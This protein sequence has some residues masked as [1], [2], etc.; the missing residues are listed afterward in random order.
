ME[1]LFSLFLVSILVI[2]IYYFKPY[3]NQHIQNLKD[4]VPTKESSKVQEILE[5]IFRNNTPEEIDSLLNRVNEELR[6]ALDEKIKF[7]EEKKQKHS[8]QAFEL[9]CLKKCHTKSL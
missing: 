3:K 1:Y 5:I 4:L 2:L 9:T 8:E 7:H 6:H